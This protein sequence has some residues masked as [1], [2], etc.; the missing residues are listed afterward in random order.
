[1]QRLSRLGLLSSVVAGAC[2]CVTLSV[3]G[4]SSGGGPGAQETAAADP[5]LLESADWRA[6]EIAGSAT[7]SG[8]EAPDVTA[9]FAAGTLSGSGGVNRY[10][11]TYGASAD[12]TITISQPAATLMAGPPEAMDQEQAY[13]EALRKATR[14]AVTADALTLLDDEGEALVRYVAQEPVALQGTTWDALAYNNGKDAL[15]SLAESSSITAVF[16]ADG[17]LTGD[18]SVNRYT[19]TYTAAGETLSIDAAIA[20]TKMAGPDELMQQ[21]AAYL[22]ALPQTATFTIEGDELWLRDAEGAALA[23]YIAAPD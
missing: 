5:A 1:M 7:L 2:L 14:F 8:A 4:C 17:S 20:T 13:F 21:E 3:A 6:T 9:V 12:G 18:A 16:G 15:V 19:T 10:T 11:A 23:H 22:A